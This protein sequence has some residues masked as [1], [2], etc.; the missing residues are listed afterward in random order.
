MEAPFPEALMTRPSLLAALL[1][2]T[3]A[4]CAA[5][6]TPPPAT[7]DAGSGAG[8]VEL[9]KVCLELATLLCVEGTKCGCPGL[10]GE[11]ACVA[12]QQPLCERSFA[13]PISGVTLGRLR[14]DPAAASACVAA[15]TAAIAGCAD[16]SDTPYAVACG[17]MF[18]DAAAVGA[19]CNPLDKGLACAD[20]AGVF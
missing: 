19:G 7:P 3:L 2:A 13:G 18:V 9:G 5:E 4:A 17:A 16:P 11:E 15:Y 10:A 20:G 6:P 14:Y 1:A 12:K 8:G